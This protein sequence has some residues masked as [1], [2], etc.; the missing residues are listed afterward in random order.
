MPAGI[1]EVKRRSARI[2]GGK[3]GHFLGDFERRA[4]GA[5]DGRKIS[6]HG[7]QLIK[8]LLT[9][10]ADKFI[11]RHSGSPVWYIDHLEIEGQSRGWLAVS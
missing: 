1:A 7:A 11:N 9:S 5:G 8:G 4:K 2:S 10:S 6:F 3:R